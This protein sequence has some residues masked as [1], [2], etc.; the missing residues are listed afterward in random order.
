[1]KFLSFLSY[2][3]QV[4]VDSDRIGNLRCQFAFKFKRSNHAPSI[5]RTSFDFSMMRRSLTA[6]RE[7]IGSAIGEAAKRGGEG[8]VGKCSRHR[9][10]EDVD[11]LT[12]PLRYWVAI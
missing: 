9:R 10:G 5:R 2:L 8:G 12:F 3:V 6:S 7:K 4:S 1:V 11:S